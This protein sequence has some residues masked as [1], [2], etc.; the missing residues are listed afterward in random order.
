MHYE[1]LRP[2]RMSN[3]PEKYEFT[4]GNGTVCVYDIATMDFVKEIKVGTKPD[5]HAVSGDGKWLYI[6]CFE[7]LY[8]ISQ[9]TLEV[10]KLFDTGKIYATNVLPDGNTLLVHDLE[11]G[12]IVIDNITDMD[13]IHIRCRTQVL[14]ERKFRC[15]IGG[16]GNLLSNGRYYLCAGWRS[17]KLYLLDT[18]NDFAVS[19]FMEADP[20]LNGG[21]D[22]VLSSDKRKAYIACHRGW[23]ERAHVAVIDI[24][25]RSITKLIPTGIGTCGLTMT[26]DERYIAASNDQDDS[27]TVIDTATD[28]VVNTPCAREGFDRLGLRGYIQ[29]IS[30]TADDSIFVYGCSGNGAIVR[31]S[32]IVSETKYTISYPMG[33]Y[34]SE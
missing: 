27:I 21:D 19:T 9:E 2:N 18:Q 7:G 24:A 22:L 11:G 29:G 14:P 30:G 23:S 4:H 10:E 16:K 31:F 3:I 13:K 32:N 12:V 1:P 15:E 34:V 28:E 6:A 17:A 5:C 8:C 25:S 26:H 33:K 20:R